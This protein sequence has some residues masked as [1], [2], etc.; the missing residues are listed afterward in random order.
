MV[1]K[2]QANNPNI[3]K[4]T[5]KYLRALYFMLSKIKKLLNIFSRAPNNAIPKL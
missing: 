5:I 3:I 1:V 2:I 4:N